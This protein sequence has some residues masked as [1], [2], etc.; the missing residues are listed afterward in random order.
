MTDLVNISELAGS[1]G[2][3]RGYLSLTMNGPLPRDGYAT[4]H[5]FYDRDS[6]SAI[7]ATKYQN[8][9]IE[10][11]SDFEGREALEDA[12]EAGEEPNDEP[13]TPTWTT[14]PREMVRA[15][16]DPIVLSTT[17]DVARTPVGSSTP[18]IPYNTWADPADDA[19]YARSVFATQDRVMT[20]DS[21]ITVTQGAEQG[22]ATG[23]KSGTINDIT[24]PQQHSA[25]V[26]V[27]GAHV[28]R[29]LD[30]A[31][32]NNGNNIGDFVYVEDVTTHSVDPEVPPEEEPGFWRRLWQGAKDINEDY[33]LMQRGVGALQTVGGAVEAVAGA[34]AVVGSGIGTVFS[35]GTATPITVVTAAGGGALA[36]KGGDDVWAG[37]QTIWTGEIH[38][39]VLDDV[40]AGAAES[41]G[42]S[43]TTTT[44]LQGAAGAVGN[45]ANIL[46][47]G[48]ERVAREV[49][50]ELAEEGTERAA[51]EAAEEA[52]EEGGERAAR[53]GTEEATE[54][55]AQRNARASQNCYAAANAAIIIARANGAEFVGGPHGDYRNGV[56]TG[57]ERGV[58][59]SHHTPPNSVNGLPIRR[60]P[61]ILMDFDDHALTASNGKMT[62][63]REY[64]S[65]QGALVSR[66][67]SGFMQAVLLDVANV[68]SIAMAQGDPTKYDAAIAMMLAYATCLVNSGI[69]G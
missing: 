56:T 1:M 13:P 47:E 43:E 65:S 6:A 54:D 46:K 28:I 68:R 25:N 64:N 22:T 19:R 38:D 42:A 18:P 21:A 61:A 66:G 63:H 48:G 53:E 51:R 41:L 5:Y 29:H 24:E 20:M 49:G 23:V 12:F 3:T 31:T 4:V 45:P 69:L 33:K 35:G 58:Y 11:T 60:G 10:H 50:E 14:T 36:V 39:T 37:L 40:V 7:Q 27:E 2:F 30:R 32:M 44:I 9:D 52:A 55:T 34:A 17:P 26:R 15:S 59:E 62:G 8:G 57:S 67:A 16:S